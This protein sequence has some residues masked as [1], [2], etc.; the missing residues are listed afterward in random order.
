MSSSGSIK[1]KPHRYSVYVYERDDAD[2]K[3]TG[4]YDVEVFIGG[5]KPTTS[6]YP[7]RC[8]HTNCVLCSKQVTLRVLTQYMRVKLTTVDPSVA[9][10]TTIAIGPNAVGYMGIQ[11]PAEWIVSVVDVEFDYHVGAGECLLPH[12]KEKLTEYLRSVSNGYDVAPAS[13]PS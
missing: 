13:A 6:A 11:R 3:P 4:V 10:V 12:N 2:G 7:R 5:V 9:A 8:I 1:R